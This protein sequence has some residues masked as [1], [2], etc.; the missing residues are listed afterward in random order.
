VDPKESV[1]L[2]ERALSVARG[3][4]GDRHPETATCEVNLARALMKAGRNADAAEKAREGLAG[5]EA[6]LGPRHPRVGA[7]LST[8]AEALAS[9]GDKTA[10]EPLYRRALEIDRQALGDSDPRTLLDARSLKALGAQR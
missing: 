9:Q 10:A 2:L 6:S 1:E 8:L 7:A 4:Y 3:R 5:F